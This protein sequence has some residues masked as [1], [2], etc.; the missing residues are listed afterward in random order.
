MLIRT[1]NHGKECGCYNKYDEEVFTLQSIKENYFNGH[2]HECTILI[3]N[4]LGHVTYYCSHEDLVYKLL[5]SLSYSIETD[6]KDFPLFINR[7]I[8]DVKTLEEWGL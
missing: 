6:P 8:G 2:Y 4:Y 1:G 3:L 7:L 5:I